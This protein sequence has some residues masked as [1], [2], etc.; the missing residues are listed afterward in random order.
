MLF[1]RG[2][3]P[4]ARSEGDLDVLV[5]KGRA[6]EACRLL[7]AAAQ[8]A[9]WYTVSFR[10]IHYLAQLLLIPPS[11]E[12]DQAVKVDFFSG[13]EWYGIGKGTVSKRLFDHLEDTQT[14][15]ASVEE[16]AA[17]VT[18]LQ[19]TLTSGKLSERDKLRVA[20]GAE[21]EKLLTILKQLGLPLSPSSIAQGGMSTFS[22]WRLRAASSGASSPASAFPWAF[23]AICAH[24]RFKSGIGTGA[25][26]VLGLSGFDGSGKSTQMTRILE[27]LER[28]GAGA[29]REIHLL[30]SWIPLPHQLF[31]R[32]ATEANYTKP[33]SEAPVSSP[34]NGGLRLAYYLLAFLVARI[35]LALG[36]MRGKVLV[37]DRSFVDFA[38][39]LTRS[40]IPDYPLP[41]RLLTFCA[42]RGLLLFLDV[43]PQLALARKRELELEKAKE[44]RERYRR[45]FSILDGRTLD[46]GAP[47]S[48]VTAGILRQLEKWTLD[49]M[50]AQDRK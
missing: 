8:N 33:Y 30:P 11:L 5:P 17:A 2:L 38:A 48:S 41:T 18:F 6:I 26:M 13:L 47:Q 49:R 45:M 23:K 16:L 42:P 43:D 10:N 21:P 14:C 19:K 28:S 15:H 44:L 34:L 7:A 22:K 37:M 36:R 46:G 3:D 27:L 29:P 40:R 12:A 32:H 1:L 50:A 4:A 24:L 35:W 39:D 25:G 31:R 20:A 9:H